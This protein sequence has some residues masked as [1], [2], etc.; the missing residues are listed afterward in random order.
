MYV[1][2]S[3]Q[4]KQKTF[5]DTMESIDTSLIKILHVLKKK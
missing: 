1:F 2:I 5:H 4:S 3:P